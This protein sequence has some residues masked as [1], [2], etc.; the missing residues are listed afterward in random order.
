[1]TT[2]IPVGTDS[3]NNDYP[4]ILQ[5]MEYS[6]GVHFNNR[7][8]DGVSNFGTLC[9]IVTGKLNSGSVEERT[10]QQA[11]YK[12]CSAI[13]LT[14]PID[15]TSITPDSRLDTFFPATGRRKKIKAFQKA[16]GVEFDLLAVK[17]SMEWAIL[18]SAATT[19]I[20]PFFSWLIAI[21]WLAF[22]IIIGLLAATFGKDLKFTT[23]RELSEQV[24][25]EHYSKTK[26]HPATIDK[27]EISVMLEQLLGSDWRPAK[28]L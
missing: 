7:D 19:M 4:G 1:M 15:R 8:L 11:Y 28:N 24:A 2:L 6:F 25:R 10:T 9:D 27:N 21:I 20:A 5:K 16:L 26:C 14:Q 22:T 18:L 13:V 17:D 23:I 3:S 12:V